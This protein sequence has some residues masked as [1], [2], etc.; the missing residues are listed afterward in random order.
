MK[1]ILVLDEMPSDCVKCQLFMGGL[2]C[3]C[4]GVHI[5]VE[6]IAQYKIPKECK[7]ISYDKFEPIKE[8]KKA[9][10]KLEKAK[11][12]AKELRKELKKAKAELKKSEE[13]NEKLRLYKRDR[14][15][16]DYYNHRTKD[17]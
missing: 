13:E 12:K 9:E 11:I 16:D 17:F 2:T 15:L 4:K 6:D 5:E 10:N 8:L 14:M 3:I 7:L 1:A